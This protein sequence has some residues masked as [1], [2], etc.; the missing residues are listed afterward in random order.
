MDEEKLEEAR[1]KLLKAV[2][3]KAKEENASAEDK[4]F[5]RLMV[6]QRTVQD[7]MYEIGKKV[8]FVLAVFEDEQSKQNLAAL[9]EYYELMLAGLE[10]FEKSLK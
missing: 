8:L 3:N 7:K 10:T 4:N 9:A 2:V 5:A 1:N 6:A